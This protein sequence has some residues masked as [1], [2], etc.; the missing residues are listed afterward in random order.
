MYAFT[1]GWLW[2]FCTTFAVG[3]TGFVVFRL[4]KIPNPALLGSIFATGLLNVLGHYPDFDTRAVSLAANITIGIMIGR[5]I[6]RDVMS[7]IIRCLR[8]VAVQTAGMLLLSLLCGLTMRAMS[9]A[10]LATSLIAGTAGGISEMI[11]FGLSTNADVSVIAFVQLW[12]MITF[13]SIIPYL[14]VITE[15]ITG[16]PRSAREQ[17]TRDALCSMPR[18]A[19][20]DY[21]LMVP[22]AAFVGWLA[23]RLGVPTG[24]MLGAMLVGGGMAL[25]LGK[26][27]TFDQ[28]LRYTAQIGLGLVTGQRVTPQIAAQLA[29][30][31]IPALAVT[32]V[33]L[34]GCALLAILLYKTSEWDLTTCLLCVA[35]TGM[36]QVASFAEELGA[37]PLTAS[38]FHTAR[39]VGIVT[40]YPWI[41]MPL[42]S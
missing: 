23:S 41:I 40:L 31:L 21:L 33:M 35:P 25:A 30:L 1:A 38:L 16:I 32:F 14:A 10:D 27:Y 36:S 7:R 15:K 3:T 37:D 12:R 9:G 5:Q 11:V 17:E 4:L 20:R 18:F 19:R 24:G 6:D 26:R 42:L 28:R 34:L 22:V 13:L 2:S 39:L 29:G 8:P